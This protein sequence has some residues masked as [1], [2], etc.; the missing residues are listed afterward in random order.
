M[1]LPDPNE[2]WEARFIALNK[3]AATMVRAIK[4]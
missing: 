1:A 4:E 3:N 2:K